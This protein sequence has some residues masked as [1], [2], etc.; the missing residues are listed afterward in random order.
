MTLADRIASYQATLEEWLRGLFH[1]LFTHPAYEKIEQEA[2]DTEDAFMLACFPD[3]F[4]I[5]SPV[6]YYTAELLPYLEDEFS[7][8]ER[9]MWDR[10]SVI[11]R[12]GHQYHF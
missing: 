2:E 6:S 4:G 10:Q 9:R 11:E 3:A 12:K 1:G 8:W 7:A 5:P